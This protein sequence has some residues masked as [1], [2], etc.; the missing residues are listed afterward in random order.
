MFHFR[1]H[2][3]NSRQE[4]CLASLLALALSCAI[5]CGDDPLP[6]LDL[7]TKLSPITKPSIALPPK[8]NAPGHW[9]KSQ[10]AV[11]IDQ[12]DFIVLNSAKERIENAM[13]QVVINVPLIDKRTGEACLT[14]MRA[15]DALPARTVPTVLDKLDSKGYQFEKV[16]V[17]VDLLNPER[18]KLY[19]Q[20][21]E[22]SGSSA[23]KFFLN[24]LREEMVTAFK[25]LARI[26]K[27]NT[28]VIG[29][30]LNTYATIEDEAAV[31]RAW[32][33]VNLVDLYH[34][35][36]SEIKS[37]NT[38]IEVGPSISWA[39]L[40]NRSL[41]SIA[42]EFALASDSLLAL[43]LTLRR[44]VWP[45][46]SLEQSPRADFIGVT[47][48]PESA[49]PPYS[50]VPN[51]EGELA[52]KVKSYYQ[53]LPLIAQ[54]PT[55]E[56]PLPIALTMIDW[57]TSNNANGGQKTDYLISLK[58]SLSV[59][60]PEWVAWRRLSNI[61]EDPPET[62]FCRAVINRGYPK[63]FC[64]AG[65]VDYLGEPRSVWEVLTATE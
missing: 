42:E 54:S 20:C 47:L 24:E 61:P 3:S 32:D 49:E 34:E 40:M 33:Y 15:S 31:N 37:I 19:H 55:L 28:I 38:E 18:L 27:I 63:D 53:A 10:L 59:I 62:S 41:P 5:S 39:T 56:S 13:S 30:E 51:P 1:Q 11:A 22:E 14:G 65:I 8:G 58:E 45:L 46:L 7:E 25:D 44:T 9:S 64:Y 23:A 48:I 57:R 6:Q 43:E 26:D 36:Y 2:S 17:Q 4:L 29:M 16:I 52:D 12:D 60:D 35:L 50:G 21:I